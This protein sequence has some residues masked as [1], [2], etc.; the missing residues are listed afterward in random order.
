M[1]QFRV[2]LKSAKSGK[3]AKSLQFCG[4]ACGSGM[5]CGGLESTDVKGL[6]QNLYKSWIGHWRSRTKELHIQNISFFNNL[7]YSVN[8]LLL[9]M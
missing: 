8:I 4:V 9:V 3:K 6:P 1:L 7:L 5:I 2:N